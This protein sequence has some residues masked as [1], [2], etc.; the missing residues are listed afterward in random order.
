MKVINT[1]SVLPE[2]FGRTLSKNKLRDI[3][4]ELRF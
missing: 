2:L 4:H 1:I 3:N